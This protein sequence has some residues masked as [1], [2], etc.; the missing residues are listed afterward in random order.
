MRYLFGLMCVCALSLMPLVGCGETE[1][2]TGRDC[3]S[4]ESC[5]DR[6]VCTRDECRRTTYLYE[7]CRN[8]PIDCQTTFPSAYHPDCSSAELE[9]CDPEA[10]EGRI[11]GRIM[12][13][14]Q[15]RPCSG[16]EWCCAFSGGGSNECAGTE[17]RCVCDW[18]DP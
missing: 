4:G 7:E 17:C 3:S 10:P 18:P 9:A 12:P 15:G 11:C 5:D 2:V 1:S 13:A 14:N 16:S 6:N 8:T